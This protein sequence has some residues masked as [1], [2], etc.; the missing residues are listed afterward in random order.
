M[1]AVGA[2]SRNAAELAVDELN[3]AAASMSPEDL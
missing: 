3:A 2:S 1:P